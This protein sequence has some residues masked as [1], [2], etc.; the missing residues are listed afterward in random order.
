MNSNNNHKKLVFKNCAPFT[1]CISEI[2]NTQIDNAKDIYLV[3]L[4]YNLMEYSN[5]YTKTSGSLWQYYRD[6]ND[7]TDAGT[8][9]IFM[10][11]ITTVLLLNLTKKNSVVTE[12]GSTKNVKI[13]VSLKYLS[14]FPRNLEEPLINCE[15]NL[16]LTSEKCA[17]FDDTKA[18][19]CTITVTKLCVPVANLSTQDNAKPLEKLKSA[20]KETINWGEGQSKV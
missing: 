15:I 16:I 13:M 20:F 3:M 17:L 9:K 12:A 10:I 6:K 11:M 19:I 14:N 1:D 7:S 2:N 18:T 8:I 4:M 5:N